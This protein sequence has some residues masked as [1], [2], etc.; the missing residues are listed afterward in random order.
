MPLWY[1][2]M[3]SHLA[4]AVQTMMD[5]AVVLEGGYYHATLTPQRDTSLFRLER[6]PEIMDPST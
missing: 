5:V 1:A 4:H 3:I 6:E 2:T